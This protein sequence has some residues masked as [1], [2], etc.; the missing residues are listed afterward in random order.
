MMPD[1]DFR[2]LDD[3][4][5]P[6]ASEPRLDA[7]RTRGR[8]IRRRRLTIATAT[9]VTA[10]VLATGGV[11]GVA[12]PY[13]RHHQAISAAGQGGNLATGSGEPSQSPDATPTYA[14]HVPAGGTSVSATFTTTGVDPYYLN[15]NVQALLKSGWLT[16]AKS[17]ADVCVKNASYQA[18][19]PHQP[20]DLLISADAAGR[21]VLV[22]T[23][24]PAY[25]TPSGIAVGSTEDLLVRTYG[26]LSSIPNKTGVMAY[27]ETVGGYS[28][29]FV[30]KNAIVAQM[31]AG[32]FANVS[33]LLN[34]A[35]VRCSSPPTGR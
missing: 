18:V 4:E 6:Y 3:G 27:T 28:I 7:V 20:G 15:V 30:V 35:L 34:G 26:N 10:L 24:S 33:D 9:A 12:G 1:L 21:I 31:Y 8:A 25:R 14:G 2:H 22:E 32:N 17:G 16:P 29:G 13:L 19:G 5:P 23:S 11:L